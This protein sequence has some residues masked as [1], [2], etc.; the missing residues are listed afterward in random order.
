MLSKPKIL[1][2]AGSTRAASV[3]KLALAVA[4]KGA[5]EAG[6]DVTV[7]DLKDFP[8]PLMDEDLEAS[9]GQPDAVTRLKALFDAH[10]GLLLACP[11]YNS[12]IT[13]V[14]KNAIDWV[15]RSDEGGSGLRYFS[16]KTVALLSASPGGLGGLRGLVHV[17]AILG[18]LGMFVVPTQTAVSSATKVFDENGDITDE[19]QKKRLFD[20]G[21]ALVSATAKLT[22]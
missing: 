21:K 4:V 18:N 1:A 22:G 3:N 8:M 2:L 9:E 19:G 12:S 10:D 5:E 14:L 7:I 15:S 11:E 13:P 6:A 16:G 20:V 17:R